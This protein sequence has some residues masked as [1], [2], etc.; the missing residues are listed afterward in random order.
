MTGVALLPGLAPLEEAMAV[1]SS[2]GIVL[3][4]SLPVAEL[5]QRAL[6]KP[7]A[8]FGRQ[9]GVNEASVA[10]LFISLV[11]IIPVLAMIR[12]MDRRGKVLNVAA[13]VSTT[14]LLAAHL[15]FTASAAPEAIPALFCAK[16]CGGAAAVVLALLFTRQDRE[17]PAAC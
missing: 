11:S 16:L 3:L 6:R 9:I 12:D 8:W 7:F 2:I 13:M 15:G 5:L 10:G 17:K 14:A 1:V 4:G